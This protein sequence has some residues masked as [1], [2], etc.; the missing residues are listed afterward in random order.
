M[1]STSTTLTLHEAKHPGKPLTFTLEGDAFQ[2]DLSQLFVP[3]EPIPD[4]PPVE[5]G[6]AQM[7]LAM[8]KMIQPFSGPVHVKDVTFLADGENL[9]VQVWKRARGLRLAP[10][11]LVLE[12]IDDPQGAA[13]LAAQIK[14][15]SQAA[16]WPGKYT[17][18]LDYWG[19]WAL[20]ALGAAGGLA[21]A[22][23]LLKRRREG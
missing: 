8:Q 15:R 4:S 17:G 12:G 23:W 22:L 9:T 11:V 16:S 3:E 21:A 7:V 18:P 6:A 19:A 13:A 10:L 5:P 1:T 14:E 20:L 2:M